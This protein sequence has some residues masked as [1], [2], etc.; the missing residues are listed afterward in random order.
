MQ[1][2]QK[3]KKKEQLLCNRCT[4]RLNKKSRLSLYRLLKAKENRTKWISAIH[5]NMDLLDGLLWCDFKLSNVK[6]P[7]SLINTL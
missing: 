6:F 4:N 7:Q 2:H 1:K 5:G 3:K